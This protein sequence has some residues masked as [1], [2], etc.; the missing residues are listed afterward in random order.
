[1]S[2]SNW[3]PNDWIRLVALIGAFGLFALGAWMLYHGIAAEGVVDLKSSILSG[4]LKSSSAGLYICFLALFVIVFVLVSLITPRSD[5]KPAQKSRAKR[6][7]PVFWG[8]LA[9]IG[10]CAIGIALLDSSARSGFSITIG[11]LTMLLVAI[12]NS[13]LRMVANEDA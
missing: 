6:L 5:S 11:V 3:K 4:T 2:T 7:M 13:L 9:A 8:L 12:V 1:M 10:V